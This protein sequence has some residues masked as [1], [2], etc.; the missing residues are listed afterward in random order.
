MIILQ[1]KFI[2][3][4]P[5]TFWMIHL[6]DHFI[7]KIMCL[8]VGSEF[9]VLHHRLRKPRHFYG[10]S[11]LG[12]LSNH[13]WQIF[14]PRGDLSLLANT[15]HIFSLPFDSTVRLYWT[16]S[17]LTKPTQSNTKCNVDS[18]T[19]HSHPF[20][21]MPPCI[22]NALCYCMYIMSHA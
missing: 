20:N 18:S 13:N 2:C 10:L 14:H 6:N 11:S 22:C 17:H 12:I 3:F 5:K 7:F 1:N 15:R 16:L 21:A 19:M 9:L 8:F 4:K